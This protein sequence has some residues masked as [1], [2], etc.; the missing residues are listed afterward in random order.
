L[1]VNGQA[2]L[3]VQSAE[4]YQKMLEE[5]DLAESTR[6]VNEG[7]AA[8]DAGETGIPANEV[9]AEIRKVLGLSERR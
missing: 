5:L 9:L 4:S 8:A 7:I 2:E 1:T 6:I 3:V